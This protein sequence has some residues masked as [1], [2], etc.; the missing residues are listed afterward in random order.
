MKVKFPE[1][2]SWF[3]KQIAESL[4]LT[5]FSEKLFK[6]PTFTI[7]KEASQNTAEKEKLFEHLCIER[8]LLEH[9]DFPFFSSELFTLVLKEKEIKGY[10]FSF[11]KSF[12]NRLK[13]DSDYPFIKLENESLFF[14][15]AEWKNIKKLFFELWKKSEGNSFYSAEVELKENKKERA[16][17]RLKLAKLLGFSRLKKETLLS[18]EDFFPLVN[19]KLLKEIEESFLNSNIGKKVFLVLGEKVLEL[20]EVFKIICSLE[21]DLVLLLLEAEEEELKKRLEKFSG[22]AGVISKEIYRGFGEKQKISP[23]V[24]V[25]GAFEHAKRLKDQNIIFFEGFTYHVLGDMFYEWEDYGSAL[26]FYE[27][28]EPYTKQPLELSLS[29]SAIFYAFGE[30]EK[31]E[32]VLRS[33]LCG[34]EKEDPAV[35]YNL[36]LVYFKKGELEKAEYHFYKAYL[37]SPE[38]ALFREGVLSFLWETGKYEDAEVLLEETESLRGVLTSREKMLKGKI[39]FIKGEKEE[40]FRILKE[41]L[42][43]RERDGETSL[44]LA[45]LLKNLK[46]QKEPS[47]ALLLEA[48]RKLSAEQFEKVLKKLKLEG[49]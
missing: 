24:M 20:K 22:K 33:Q 26:R 11:P 6:I 13:S 5:C 8:L 27:L 34:C 39:K 41:F 29:K 15:P 2:F 47:E 38:E 44:I 25:M 7:L 48:K 40:A 31:A 43:S 16:F 36:G 17:E 3:A 4:S 12:I 10:L 18:L 19:F 14:Y 9:F 30:L 28:A 45:Y 42:D 49:L 23:L 37:L 21:R 1:A 35:H 32:R 46:N